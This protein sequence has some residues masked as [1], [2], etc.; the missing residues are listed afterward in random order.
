MG[1]KVKWLSLSSVCSLRELCFGRIVWLQRYNDTSYEREIGNAVAHKF[2][3][4]CTPLTY[5]FVMHSG[6]RFFCSAADDNPFNIDLLKPALF[7]EIFYAEIE[8]SFLTA[9]P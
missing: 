2:V 6:R 9:I 8:R 7:I 5:P 4:L 3:P 1:K